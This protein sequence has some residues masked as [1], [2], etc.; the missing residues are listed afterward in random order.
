[1]TKRMIFFLITHQL[2]LSLKQI[3]KQ[4]TKHQLPIITLKSVINVAMPIAL[5]PF[6]TIYNIKRKRLTD[7]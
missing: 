3:M 1:M 7:R 2:N 6:T 5:L 4:N